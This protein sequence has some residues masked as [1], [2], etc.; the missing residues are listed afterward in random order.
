MNYED[1]HLLYDR[2]KNGPF[3]DTDGTDAL[4]MWLW[5]HVGEIFEALDRA[6]QIIERVGTVDG[7]SVHQCQ[8][9][10]RWLREYAG[11]ES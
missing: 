7:D 6:E 1:G 4:D 2:W 11:R 3:T 10:K 8:C 9:A 5:D